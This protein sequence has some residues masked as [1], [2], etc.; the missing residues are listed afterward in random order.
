MSIKDFTHNIWYIRRKTHHNGSRF[1]KK[2]AILTPPL[3]SRLQQ[4]NFDTMR[5]GTQVPWYEQPNNADI[6]RAAE[7]EAA[8]RGN[9]RGPNCGTNRHCAIRNFPEIATSGRSAMPSSQ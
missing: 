6:A 4:I 5:G 3:T 2:I 1:L 7:S 9:L 8:A